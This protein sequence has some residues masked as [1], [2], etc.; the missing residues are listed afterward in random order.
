MGIKENSNLKLTFISMI[1]SFE[2]KIKLS[3]SKIK[4]ELE[5]HLDSINQNTNEIL[6]NHHKIID[7]EKKVD[8]LTQRINEMDLMFEN[9]KSNSNSNF[10]Y[11]GILYKEFSG[12]EKKVLYY[13]LSKN[14]NEITLPDIILYTGLE[15]EKVEQ[16]IYNLIKSGIP[17]IKTYSKDDKIFI[18]IDYNFKI[19]Q[20]KENFLQIKEEITN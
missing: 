18:G 3:F 6:Y 8:L 14:N 2:E 9:Q 19:Q 15:I 4:Y 1:K 10:D 20:R 12:I 7:L 5:D 16:I 17:I 13:L 11:K